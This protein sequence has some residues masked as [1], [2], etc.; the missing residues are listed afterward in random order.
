[1]NEGT[2]F[3]FESRYIMRPTA[4]AMKCEQRQEEYA[5]VWQDL[6]NNFTK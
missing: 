5:A 2:A 3:M 1:M 4:Q 6:T